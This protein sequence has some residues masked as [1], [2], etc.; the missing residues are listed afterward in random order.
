MVTAAASK[1][2]HKGAAVL[3]VAEYGGTTERSRLWG[4]NK[5]RHAL[6]RL[7][8]VCNLLAHDVT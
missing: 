6:A 3:V 4:Q 5:G 1:L 7:D 8:R 2:I